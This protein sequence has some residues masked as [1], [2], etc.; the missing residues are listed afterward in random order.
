MN[1]LATLH[2]IL[3]APLSFINFNSDCSHKSWCFELPGIPKQFVKGCWTVIGQF[4]LKSIPIGCSLSIQTGYTHTFMLHLTSKYAVSCF[5]S[6]KQLPAL[7]LPIF[8]NF[9]NSSRLCLVY[10]YFA[11]MSGYHLAMFCPMFGYHLAMFCPMFGL[12]ASLF[13][14]YHMLTNKSVH[15]CAESS[16][17]L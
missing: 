17:Y 6:L 1:I 5:Q 12:F 2:A 14:T 13:N 10:D 11:P 8:L 9:F 16:H 4:W 3:I 7:S 15:L